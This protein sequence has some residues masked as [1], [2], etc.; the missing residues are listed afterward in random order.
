MVIP[1]P[2]APV[3]RPIPV[4]FFGTPDFAVPTLA[5]LTADARFVV[6]LVVTQPA[7]PQGRGQRI[8]RSAVNERAD[9]LGLPVFTPDRLRGP[10]ALNR[11]QA[12]DAALFVVA[13]YGKILRPDILAISARGILNVHASLLPA[14]RGASPISAAI[15]DGVLETGVTIMLMDVGLDTGPILAQARVPIPPTATTGTLSPTLANLG[16]NLLIETAVRWIDGTATPTAQNASLATTTRLLTKA[17]GAVDWSQPAERIARMERAYDPWPGVFSTLVGTRLILR[18]IRDA[19]PAKD[20]PPGTIVAAG[21]DGLRVR[22][23]VGDV[24]IASVQPEGRQAMSAD[25]FARGRAGLI[26]SRFGT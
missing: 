1:R 25:A 26:G 8:R 9:Q 13:A 5:A 24:V 16:A 7:R 11:L 18:G 23:G 2:E 20:A 17:D 19:L 4:V 6:R 14:Y 21:A 10:E 12:T 22:V 15:L 3:G